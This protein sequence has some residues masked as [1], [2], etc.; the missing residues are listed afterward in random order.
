MGRGSQGRC[1]A[2]RWTGD[3]G[4]NVTVTGNSVEAARAVRCSQGLGAA[5]AVGAGCPLGGGPPALSLPG[6][7]PHSL[8]HT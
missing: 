6:G 7:W 1:S 3:A 4:E 8:G 2:T 5:A